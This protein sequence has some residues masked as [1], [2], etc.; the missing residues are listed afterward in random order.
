M[1]SIR[2]E[3]F[4][5]RSHLP[6]RES[7]YLDIKSLLEQVCAEHAPVVLLSTETN[8]LGFVLR[9]F[10]PEERD[11]V[12]LELSLRLR[13]AAGA[14]NTLYHIS[15]ECFALILPNFDSRQAIDQAKTFLKVL[16]APFTVGSVSYHLDSTVGISHYPNHAKTVSE[17]V[18]TSAFA[19]QLA[20]AAKSGYAAFD[21][22]LDRWERHRF[23]LTTELEKALCS[24]TQ[25]SLAYQP[26]VNLQS[27]KCESVEGLC[28]WDHPELGRIPPNDFLPYVEQTPLMMPFTVNTLSIGFEC[29][30]LGCIG[31]FD[32]TLAINL[33]PA[34]FRHPDL[35][36]Q[37]L[38]QF[39]FYNVD[40]RRVHFEIT[41]TG[42]M[43]Q[44][45]RA[46]HTLKEIRSWGSKIS[47]DDFG[48]GHSSLAYLADLPI[49]TIKIDK[50]FIKNLSL[51]WGE[52]IVSATATL[53][54]KLGLETVGEG[55]ED[56]AQY[57]KCRDLGV[58]YGQG[59]YIAKPMPEKDFG[60]WIEEQRG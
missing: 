14:N 11:L 15:Q 49:D 34:L 8:G 55:I 58:T 4:D 35:R 54:E 47:V 56:E 53:A 48:T 36:E 9:T 2:S 17:L 30:S 18:R 10:G 32:G 40:P 39:R 31:Y 59:F 46:I 28:R 42:I 43:E 38:E 3:L 29:L 6:G 24:Q 16:G 52:A 7:F 51:P 19:C 21:E 45:K 41:E 37:L 22:D 33:S 1:E 5:S 13:D 20:R 44:P 60:Q 27:G 50:H 25:I 12:V 57:Q 23:H 26:I